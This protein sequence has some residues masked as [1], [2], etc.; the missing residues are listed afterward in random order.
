MD[1]IINNLMRWLVVEFCFVWIVAIGTFVIGELDIIPNGVAL[2]NYQ[3]VFYINLVNV[4]LLIICV[5]LSLKLF[6]LNTQRGLRRMNKEEALNS[7]HLWSAIRLGLLLLCIEVGIVSYFLSID[8]TG[9][10]CTCIAL[11]ITLF[12]IPSRKKIETFLSSKEDEPID[13]IS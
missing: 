10:L 8:S 7:Y 4:L 12:C 11:V 1:K 2:E 5:P 13:D 6:V 3:V 9:E